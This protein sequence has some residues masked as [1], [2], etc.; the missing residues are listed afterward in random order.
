MNER[1]AGPLAFVKAKSEGVAIVHNEEGVLGKCTKC[2]RPIDTIHDVGYMGP[3]DR[4]SSE[5]SP[6]MDFETICTE[7][8]GSPACV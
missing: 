8:E 2:S 1:L 4:D 6:M 3:A 7:C 5:C